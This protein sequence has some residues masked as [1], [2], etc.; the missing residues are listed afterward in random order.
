MKKLLTSLALALLTLTAHAATREEHK[1]KAIDRADTY[2]TYEHNKHMSGSVTIKTKITVTSVEA[3]PGWGG[4]YR[5]T[6]EAFMNYYNSYGRSVK[7]DSCK[8]EVL[9]QEKGTEIEISDLTPK[10]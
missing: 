3:V 9:T 2:F 1:A 4:R 7:T 10:T 5:T 8:F 6:G